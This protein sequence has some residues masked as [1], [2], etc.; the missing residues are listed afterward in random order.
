MSFIQT[1]LYG[2]FKSHF[3]AILVG[4]LLF[5]LMHLPPWIYNGR[6]DIN[7]PIEILIHVVRWSAFHFVFVGI[8]KKYYSIVPVFILHTINNLSGSFSNTDIR[9]FNITIVVYVLAACLLYWQTSKGVA[10]CQ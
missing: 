3:L 6:L 9:L 1:R 5:S 7:Q 2:F 8:F 10:K 4:S